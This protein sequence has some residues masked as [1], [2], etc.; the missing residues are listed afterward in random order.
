MTEHGIGAAGFPAFVE[1]LR[2]E[3]AVRIRE[4]DLD[5]LVFYLLQSTHF[6]TRPPIEPA[7]SAKAVVEALPASARERFL[8]GDKSLEPQVPRDVRARI[9]ALVRALDSGDP[10][11]R[12]AYFRALVQSIAPS[13]AGR[14]RVLA[15]EYVRA[16]RFLYQKEFVAQRAD[17][18][19]EAVEDLYRSRGLST[20][21]AVEAGY[22]VYLGLG[23][24][25]SLEPARQIRR[26]LIVGPGL[27][28]APR[29]GLLE[30]GQPES[31]Q[32]WAVIDALLSLGLARADDLEVVGA[33]INPR[34]VKHLRRSRT[35][36]P[37]LHLVSG[38]AETGTVRF[39][40]EYRDYFTDLGR[41]IG[42]IGAAGRTARGHLEKVVAVEP[43]VAR[44]LEA[45]KLDVVTERLEAPPF[46]LA[47][48]TNILP[49]FDDL[50]LTLTI[51]NIAA[52]LAPAGVFLHNE[53]RPSMQAI[54]AGAG[55]GFVQSRQAIIASVSGA[56]APLG[57][58]VWL[59]RKAG[60][61]RP[62]DR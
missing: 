14:D 60:G 43:A 59:Y 62:A 37:R 42:R 21:T 52:M 23:V 56:A 1:R 57:D 41:S 22:L 49:Y 38:I 32:P 9:A 3:H 13:R 2:R 24:V 16:M 48:A 28:L 55:L 33:D 51:G 58:S 25:R 4:G 6:T 39:S 12:L 47:I 11:P 35:E 15:R 19:V 27:D 31:Y 7:L 5:H 46:D 30:A 8:A 40:G 20:D 50:E 26:V 61:V 45:A 54:A 18:P 34:V 44:T 10:N 36:P 29:T 53:V 17:R